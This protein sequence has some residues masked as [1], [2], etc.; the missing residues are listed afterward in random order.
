M[1][2]RY[3]SGPLNSFGATVDKVGEQLPAVA[4]SL[5]GLI[6]VFLGLTVTARDSYSAENRR[7]VRAKYRTRCWTAFSGFLSAI[8]SASLGL[9]GIYL[10]H[11]IGWPDNMGIGC[12]ALAIMLAVAV[13]VMAIREN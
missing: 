13:A 2:P 12:L 10:K 6:L 11:R 7:A 1:R 4:I 8:V 5:A 9:Y 3:Y